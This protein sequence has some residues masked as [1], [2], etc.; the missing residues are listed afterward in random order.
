VRLVHFGAL[1]VLLDHLLLA[2]LAPLAIQLLESDRPELLP[3]G[4]NG[5]RARKRVMQACKSPFINFG[6]AHIPI[7]PFTAK[8]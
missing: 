3:Q 7:H 1:D 2:I 8:C 6:A 4:R 5:A